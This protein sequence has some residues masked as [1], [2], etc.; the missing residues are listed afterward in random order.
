MNA[1]NRGHQL[2]GSSPASL[3]EA[4]GWIGWAVDDVHGS[5]I[6]RLADVI[7]DAQGRLPDWLVVNELRFGRGR[8]FLVPAADATGTGGRVWVPYPRKQVQQSAG[9]GWARRTSQAERR[10]RKHYGLPEPRRSAA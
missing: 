2:A 10:L 4:A 6:G 7:S 1:A 8:H 9:L 3:S 5:R